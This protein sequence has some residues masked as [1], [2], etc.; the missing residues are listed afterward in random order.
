VYEADVL[1]A[2]SQMALA[3]AGFSG[4]T[5]AFTRTPGRL[6]GIEKYRLRWL[7]GTAFAAMFTPLVAVALTTLRVAPEIGIRTA[8]ATL[9]AVTLLVYVVQ[10]PPTL[11]YLRETPSIFRLPVLVGLAA[12]N[13]VNAMLQSAV[14]AGAWPDHAA[15]VL[16]LGVVW[17]L[18][19]SAYQF[20]RLLFV[21]PAQ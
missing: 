17:L 14:A 15:G 18:L 1:L 21:H 8:S 16:V 6:S 2:L 19:H 9:A 10:A 13:A 3:V 11:R 20:S 4:I 7:F 5:I 12:G